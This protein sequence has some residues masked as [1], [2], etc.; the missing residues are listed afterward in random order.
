MNR[1]TVCVNCARTDL[2]GA[3]AAETRP[4]DPG[5]LIDPVLPGLPGKGGDYDAGYA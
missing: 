5:I 3:W 2:W 4:L 1:G